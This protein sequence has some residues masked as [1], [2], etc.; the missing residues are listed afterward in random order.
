MVRLTAVALS[1]VVP[2]HAK[3]ESIL[4]A[5]AGDQLISSCGFGKRLQK[6][7][8]DRRSADQSPIVQYKQQN[9]PDFKV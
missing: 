5:Y 3:L 9:K 6:L 7:G 8:V 4:P 2:I 1:C